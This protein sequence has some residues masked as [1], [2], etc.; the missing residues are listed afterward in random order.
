MA[1]SK[2]KIQKRLA[3]LVL[4]AL[5]CTGGVQTFFS[6]SVAEAGYD[7]PIYGTVTKDGATY[8]ITKINGTSSYHYEDY[9]SG[10]S[11]VANKK[12]LSWDTYSKENPVK[13]YVATLTTSGDPED[14]PSFISGYGEFAAT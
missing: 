8:N 12:E 7:G 10:D 3:K 14:A 2:P 1:K 6:P 4:A 13:G 11:V 9:M 5:L